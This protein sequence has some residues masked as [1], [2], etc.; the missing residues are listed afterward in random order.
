MENN[1][2]GVMIW[3]IDQDDDQLTMLKAATEVRIFFIWFKCSIENLF[4]DL[5]LVLNLNLF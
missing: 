1:L 4:S 3:A 5:E 2:G